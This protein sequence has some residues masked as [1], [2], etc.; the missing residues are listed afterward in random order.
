MWVC[1]V[2]VTSGG[3]GGG[4]CGSGGGGGGGEL[5]NTCKSYWYTL[6]KHLRQIEF[7]RKFA[8]WNLNGKI[9]NMQIF[10]IV[11]DLIFGN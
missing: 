2:V 6:L 1:A 7:E 4:G 3:G 10:L 8:I 11:T 9:K 5:L